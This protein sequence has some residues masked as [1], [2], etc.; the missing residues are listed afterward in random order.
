MKCLTLWQPWA[1]LIAD[2]IKTLETRSWEF[3][4]YEIGDTIGIHASKRKPV[5]EEL[6]EPIHEYMLNTYGDAWTTSIPYGAVIATV[7]VAGYHY[8]E[9]VQRCGT[10]ALTSRVPC[11]IK[12]LSDGPYVEIPIDPYGDFSKGRYAWILED[13]QKFDEPIPAKGRQ[14]LW[15]WKEKE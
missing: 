3:P 6:N 4:F 9:Q 5:K 2:G 14:K 8:I 1:T 12:S 7:K 13:L 11:Q 10:K 15:L